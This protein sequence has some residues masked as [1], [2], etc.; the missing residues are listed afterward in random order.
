MRGFLAQE[1]IEVRFVDVRAAPI[2][3]RAALALARSHRELLATRGPKLH[4]IDP[5]R[6]SDDELARLVLGREGTLR[7]PTLSDGKTMLC[8]FHQPS[9][10]ALC[11][12]P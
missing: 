5:S 10:R 6:A 11:G 3:R 2:E 7:A 12:A 4:Q 8:G 1:Q 9:L